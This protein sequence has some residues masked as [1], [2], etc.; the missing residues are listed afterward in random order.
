MIRADPGYSVTSNIVS[1]HNIDFD[2]TF[3]GRDA[4]FEKEQL[5]FQCFLGLFFVSYCIARA[6]VSRKKKKK[7]DSNASTDLWICGSLIQ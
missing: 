6:C 1:L 7:N 4:R 3:H 2:A 5:A